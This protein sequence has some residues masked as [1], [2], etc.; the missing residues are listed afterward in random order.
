MNANT[1]LDLIIF[2]VADLEASLDYYTRQLGFQHVSEQDGPTFRY[3][4]GPAGADYA[5]LTA[6]P[7]T[8]PAGAVEIFFKSAD[9]AAQHTALAERGLEVSPIIEKPFGQV[10]EFHSP[11]GQH[12]TVMGQVAA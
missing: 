7:K 8:P 10:F 5:L 6:T 2:Y 9:L 12:I 4:T 3:L 1:R 11:D